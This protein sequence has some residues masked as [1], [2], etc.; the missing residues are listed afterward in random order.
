MIRPFFGKLG[1]FEKPAKLALFTLAGAASYGLL[2]LVMGAGAAMGE[3]WL[4]TV[5]TVLLWDVLFMTLDHMLGAPI[6]KR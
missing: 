3:G 4:M 5:I 6:K 1:V 2:L